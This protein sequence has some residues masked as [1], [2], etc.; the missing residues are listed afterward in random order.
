METNRQDSVLAFAFST[1]FDAVHR[2]AEKHSHLSLLFSHLLLPE[3]DAGILSRKYFML[4][5]SYEKLNFY[6]LSYVLR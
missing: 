6:D 1:I 2:T 4:T 3:S 5:V